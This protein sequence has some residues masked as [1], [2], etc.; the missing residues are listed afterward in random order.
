MSIIVSKC[1]NML[2]SFWSCLK[3]G[4]TVVET[5]GECAVSATRVF[6]YLSMRQPYAVLA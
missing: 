4:Y 2:E 1:Q 5:Q 3:I 6:C